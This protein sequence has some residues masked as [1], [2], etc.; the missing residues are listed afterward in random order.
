MPAFRWLLVSLMILSV[1]NQVAAQL[2]PLEPAATP[3]ANSKSWLEENVESVFDSA[4]SSDVFQPAL[5]EGS[6]V[7]LANAPLDA[8]Q[9]PPPQPPVVAKRLKPMTVSSPVIEYRN[10][11]RDGD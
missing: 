8:K 11:A 5:L 1:P 4:I 6:M 2:T 10:R 7:A 9:P 3:Q